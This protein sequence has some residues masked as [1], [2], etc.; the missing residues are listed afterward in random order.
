MGQEKKKFK[1][2]SW[3]TY[4]LLGLELALMIALVTI[5]II[6]LKNAQAGSGGPF[7]KWLIGNRVWFFVL[8][9]LP[10]IIL[11]LFNVYL[12]IKVM[13]EASSKE[14]KQMSKEEL[15]E[16]ARRQAREELQKELAKQEAAEPDEK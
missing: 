2:P 7:I 4:L 6:A 8:I 11:F 3:A 14:F 1:L 9:V 13:N 15:L 16:E 5:S 12:L 10:L